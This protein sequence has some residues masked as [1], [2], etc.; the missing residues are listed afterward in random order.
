[1]PSDNGTPFEAGSFEIAGRGNHQKV[2]GL[3]SGIWGIYARPAPNGNRHAWT[4]TH[5]PT[6][7]ALPRCFWRLESAKAVAYA[8]IERKDPCWDEMALSLD[9][10]FS[11]EP[12]LA[13]RGR[14]AWRAA[15]A[16]A[17]GPTEEEPW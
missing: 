3:T 13:Q 11:L 15:L 17:F 14:A 2:E 6:G 16:K 5:I 9:K 1:M 8:L 7:R 12:A 4:I 10:P